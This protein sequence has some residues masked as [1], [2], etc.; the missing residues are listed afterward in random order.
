MLQA[1]SA[2]ILGN[3][4]SRG[5]EGFK[6]SLME[7]GGL[8]KLQELSKSGS[9]ASM[10][11]RKAAA[12]AYTDITTGRASESERVGV[13]PNIMTGQFQRCGF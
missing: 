5:D 8:E 12:R 13:L 7:A 4:A 11:V 9:M 3:L 1:L 10:P 6:Q 2:A